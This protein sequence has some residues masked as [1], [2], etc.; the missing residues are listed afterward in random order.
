MQHGHQVFI[1]SIAATCT[2]KEVQNFVSLFGPYHSLE[3][4]EK[5]EKLNNNIAT[6]TFKRKESYYR[7]VDSQPHFLEGVELKIKSLKRGKKLAQVEKSIATRRLYVTC[8]PFSAT[9]EEIKEVFSVFGE[10][11]LC[12]VCKAKRRRTSTTDYGFVTFK[13]RQVAKE[14]LKKKFIPFENYGK[15]LI[16]NFFNSKG[17]QGQKT[18]KRYEKT[19]TFQKKNSRRYKHQ[20]A[21]TP[22][23]YAEAGKRQNAHILINYEKRKRSRRTQMEEEQLR[24]KKV[25]EEFSRLLS[26]KEERLPAFRKIQNDRPVWKNHRASNLEYNYDGDQEIMSKAVF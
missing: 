6:L 7:M 20:K 16:V 3:Y 21:H 24:R 13:D 17:S 4:I 10:V 18:T 12:Y 8:I 22:R 15:N 11:E 5:P 2:R 23:N 26:S 1:S 25:E 9:D 14:V 19:N